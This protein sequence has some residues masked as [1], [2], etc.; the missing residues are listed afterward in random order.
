ME[1]KL[2]LINPSGGAKHIPIMFVEKYKAQGWLVI[3]PDKLDPRGR[4]K[5]M[6]W[7]QYDQ[8]TP[9]RERRIVNEEFPDVKNVLKVEVF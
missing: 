8:N 2:W 1:P 9:G 7:P 3:P 5:Q 4:P 6:Y